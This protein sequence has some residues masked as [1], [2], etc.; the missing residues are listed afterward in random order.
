MCVCVC[1]C[2]CLCVFVCVCARA[3]VYVRVFIRVCVCG[4]GVIV[5]MCV[6]AYVRARVCL[7]SGHG[8]AVLLPLA[9]LMEIEAGVG[10]RREV[11]DGSKGK[12][13]QGEPGGV[14]S[15]VTSAGRGG[16]GGQQISRDE[17]KRKL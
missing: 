6:R 15:N 4:G 5:C 13:V 3:R 10:R 17:I 2:V 12:K 11:R 14:M 7:W 1:V 16:V 9:P 8:I